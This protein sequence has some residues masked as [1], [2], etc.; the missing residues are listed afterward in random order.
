MSRPHPLA[1]RLYRSLLVIYPS[2]LRRE[3]GDQML[4]AVRDARHES[5]AG[6]L[7]FWTKAYIELLQSS[8]REHLLMLREN[9]F[10][11]PIVVHT[12]IFAVALTLLGAGLSL[13]MDQFLRRGADQPQIDM[14]DW[15]AGEI[16]SGELPADVIPPGYVDLE[17]SLQPVVIFYDDQ[18][19][20]TNGTGYLDQKLPSPPPGVLDFVRQ[21]GQKKVTWQPRP[22][23]RIAS[24]IKRVSGKTPGF[25]LAGRSLRLVESQKSLLHTI[26]FIVWIFVMALLCI[27]AMFL[28][29]SRQAGQIPSQ[30]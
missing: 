1:L 19:K 29:R 2:R 22:G 7:A 14:T 12:V 8:I 3:Y 11:K 6:T 27:G 20:P 4:L 25:V 17:R 15:Y 5:S 24:V 23:V 21:H 30:I 16:A 13:T 28:N 10:K 18:G 9:S 26:G